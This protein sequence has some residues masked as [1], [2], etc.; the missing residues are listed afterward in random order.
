MAL[1]EFVDL[2]PEDKRESFKSELSSVVSIKSRE[3]ASKLLTENP[4]LKSE[5]DATISRTTAEYEKRF[6]EEKL[7]AIVDEEVRKRNPAKD[8]KDLRLEKL[9]AMLADQTKQVLLKDQ[10]A[11]AISALVAD[12]L[13]V[14]LADYVVKESDDLTMAELKKIADP[15]KA[16][17]AA[18]EKKIR[19]EMVGNQKPP[20]SG[21]SAIRMK[22]SDF[23]NL[24]PKDQA[25]FFQKGGE[26]DN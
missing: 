21:G 5:R 11:K 8:E 14:E 12:G 20:K 13:P 23:E 19:G 22:L 4:F 3:D 16:L 10:K 9:E 24:S 26:L 17:L 25:A 6:K 1:Q 2:I 15:I 18:Q 7:A